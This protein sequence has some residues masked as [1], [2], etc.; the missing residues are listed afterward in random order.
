M[1]TT[2]ILWIDDE[3]ELLK[4]HILFLEG[5]GIKVE[6]VNNGSDALSMLEN[7]HVDMVFLDEEMTVPIITMEN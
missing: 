3:I 1:T 2:K 5:K 4:P 7:L 6:T